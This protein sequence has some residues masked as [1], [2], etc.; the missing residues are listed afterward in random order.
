M[1]RCGFG[2]GGKLF[3]GIFLDFRSTLDFILTTILGPPSAPRLGTPSRAHPSS[4]SAN[5]PV[6]HMR[7][8]HAPSSCEFDGASALRCCCRVVSDEVKRNVTCP[9]RDPRA[10]SLADE[11]DLSVSHVEATVW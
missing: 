1:R 2:W 8:V 10:L 4:Q 5:V 9:T 6:R 3:I 11:P 7:I